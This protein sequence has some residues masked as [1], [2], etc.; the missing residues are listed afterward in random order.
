MPTFYA[1]YDIDYATVTWNAQGGTASE[2]SRQVQKGRAVGTLPTW[3]RSGY[4]FNGWFTAASGGTQINASTIVNNNVTYYA[5]SVMDRVYVNCS[6]V[7]DDD[8][9]TRGEGWTMDTDLLGFILSSVEPNDNQKVTEGTA[10]ALPQII[11]YRLLG[12]NRVDTYHNTRW[13]ADANFTQFLGNSGNT[14]TINSIQ[15]IY[16]AKSKI[17]S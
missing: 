10:L 2:S 13:Y 4:T 17:I 3:T 7:N 12:P 1:Q 9:P 6:V 11:S 15:T 5:Q 16:T 8:T 14:F